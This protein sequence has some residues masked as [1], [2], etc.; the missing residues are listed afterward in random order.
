MKSDTLTRMN[1]FRDRKP[2]GASRSGRS[3]RPGLLFPA[4][5]LLGLLLL[6]FPAES[7]GH[8]AAPSRP[9]SVS[10]LD[11]STE[12]R[13]WRGPVAEVRSK[14]GQASVEIRPEGSVLDAMLELSGPPAD[15]SGYSFLL[16]DVDSTVPGILNLTLRE[17]DGGE[18]EPWI[19]VVRLSGERET[20]AVRLAP[21]PDGD[22]ILGGPQRD[23]AWNPDSEDRLTLT[24][25]SGGG[26]LKVFG[27][28]LA[29]KAPGEGT[30]DPD[31]ESA[32][33]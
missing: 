12:A 7:T 23:R 18:L 17:S 31:P 4:L 32:D 26:N 21:K 15:W 2:P 20:L 14:E 30:E 11:A 27:I 19:A 13:T 10:I 6:P 33:P 9:E 24:L 1:D 22:L 29:M 3:R 25:T 5:G 28:V 16:L 8:D